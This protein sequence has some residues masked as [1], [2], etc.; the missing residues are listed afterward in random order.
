[1]INDMLLYLCLLNYSSKVKRERD[2][3]AVV[4]K[5]HKRLGH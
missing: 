4:T 5:S 1:M 2:R 3:V